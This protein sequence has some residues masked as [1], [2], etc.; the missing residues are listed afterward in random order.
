MADTNQHV[1]RF[2]TV[3]NR[4]GFHS[5]PVMRFV[6]VAQRFEADIQVVSMSRQE[7]TIDGKSAMELMLLGAVQGTRLRITACGPDA[8]QAADALVALVNDHFGINYDETS[9]SS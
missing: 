1:V 7:E 2:V 8:A 9:T 4:E 5:R 3:S 6:D